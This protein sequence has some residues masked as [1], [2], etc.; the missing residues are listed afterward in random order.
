MPLSHATRA[1]DFVFVS[2]QVATAHDGEVY[3]GDFARE[4]ESALDNVEAVLAAAGARPDQIV[5]VG[6]FLSNAT[7]FA[8]FNE[9]YRRRFADAPPARTTVVVTSATR[10]SGSRSTRSPTSAEPRS[11]TRP[12]TRSDRCTIRSAVDEVRVVGHRLATSSSSRDVLLLLGRG[13]LARRPG[14]ADRGQALAVDPH[15]HRDAAQPGAA[16]VVVEGVPARGSAAQS[17]AQVGQ[18]GDR[19]AR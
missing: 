4:V 3:I 19:V 10:T 2:G 15:R 16:L 18:R 5:K 6:A 17:S 13:E 11:C 1:G 8:P 12:A 14:H 7:L 9:V